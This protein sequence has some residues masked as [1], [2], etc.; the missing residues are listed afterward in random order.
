MSIAKTSPLYEYWNS[1]QGED[2]EKK[3]LLKIN[4]NEPAS[5]LFKN[6]PYKW[7]ILYQ[8]V[9]RNV[10]RGDETSLKGLMVLLSTINKK[11]K[12]KSL[13]SLE[14]FLD[15]HLINKLRYEKHQDIISTKNI[16]NALIILWN[17][18][19]NPYELE[20]KKDKSHMY[21]ITGMFFYQLRKLFS[22]NK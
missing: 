10:M 20:I 17:I 5:N 2:A 16:F 15:K 11:E 19:T 7:E 14:G 8:S 3:R 18:F 9:V 1:D 12:D 13:I 4:K 21:E 6:E 22:F